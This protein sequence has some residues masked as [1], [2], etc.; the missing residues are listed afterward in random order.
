MSFK[1]VQKKIE[2]QGHSAASAGA[3]LAS[4]TR[5]ASTAAKKKNP[6]LKRVKGGNTTLSTGSMKGSA[7]AHDHNINLAADQKFDS[8][9]QARENLAMKAD[10]CGHDCM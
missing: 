7:L 10:F 4:A 3:I 6:K 9:A 5:N 1:S 8:G 2:G